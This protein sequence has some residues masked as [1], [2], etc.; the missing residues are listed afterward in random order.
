MFAY[1]FS[2]TDSA[3]KEGQQRWLQSAE[4]ESVAMHL[5]V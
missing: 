5:W 4:R 1:F 2:V 3:N